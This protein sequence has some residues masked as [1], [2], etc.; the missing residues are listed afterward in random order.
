MKASMTRRHIRSSVPRGAG[1]GS[2]LTLATAGVLAA[3]LMLP[4]ETA[5]LMPGLAAA[6][7]PG[8]ELN[9]PHNIFRPF[10]TET[11][12]V[13]TVTGPNCTNPDNGAGGADVCNTTNPFLTENFQTAFGNG[14]DCETCHQPQLGWNVTPGFLADRFN[15]TQGKAEQFRV[16]DTVTDPRICGAPIATTPQADNAAAVNACVGSMSVAQKAQAYGLFVNLSIHRIAL[17]DD[18]SKDDFTI[19]ATNKSVDGSISFG[20]T[21]VVTGTCETSAT[22]CGPILPTG[23]DSQ[24]PCVVQTGTP[25]ATGCL[26]TIGVFRRPLITT[27]TFFDSSV[28]WD[29]RQNVC[30]TITPA[31]GACSATNFKTPPPPDLPGEGAILL[32]NQVSGAAQTLPLSAKPTVAQDKMAAHFMTGIFTAMVESHGAGRLTA[33]GAHGGPQFLADMAANKQQPPCTP[34]VESPKLFSGGGNPPPGCSTARGFNLFVPF[35]PKNLQ[36]GANTPAGIQAI[37]AFCDNEDRDDF[38]SPGKLAIAC[39]EN[40]FDNHPV[41]DPIVGRATLPAG[42]T[43]F[44]STAPPNARCTSCHA[45]QNVGDNPNIN[46]LLPYTPNGGIGQ[47]PAEFVGGSTL[48]SDDTFCSTHPTDPFCAS[49]TFNLPDFKARTSML[50]LYTL[51]QKSTGATVKLTDPG[52][53]LI[54][55]KFGNAGFQKPPVLRDLEPRAPFFHNGAA[56]DLDRLVEFYN[57]N[58]SIGLTNREKA[59]LV[60]FLQAL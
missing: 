21:P 27:N 6:S 2:I 22:G 19:S 60:A 24:N 20:P 16:N 28:L 44:G 29:G 10:A 32:A 5:A 15:D 33:Q 47:N 25:S 23:I 18:P 7:E 37:F 50:P 56:Q 52:Q 8:A 38:G 34:L 31:P 12:E 45:A 36:A 53:A 54:T 43:S 13:Q 4:G 1:F 48:A 46:F 59:D 51:T 57:Q 55:H 39:G 30:V 3:V 58:F 41:N 14:Q 35:L 11:G 49:K 26:P 40:I 17:K 42:Q 9:D